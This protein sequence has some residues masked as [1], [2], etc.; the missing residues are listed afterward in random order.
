AR[1]A[2]VIF[3][4]E[5]GNS[6]SVF[7]G[8]HPWLNGWMENPCATPLLIVISAHENLPPDRC[9]D[10]R[11]GR[12]RVHPRCAPRNHKSENGNSGYLMTLHNLIVDKPFSTTTLGDLLA[13]AVADK[14]ERDPSLLR[15]AIQNIDRWLAHGVISTPERFLRWRELCEQAGSDATA[16]KSI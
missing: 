4:L 1:S 5:I 15:I 12:V 3:K 16:L 7:I 14:L 9:P 11:Q 6:I 2:I 8:V 13:R 10:R